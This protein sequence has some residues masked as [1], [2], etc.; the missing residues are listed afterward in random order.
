MRYINKEEPDFFKTFKKKQKPNKWSDLPPEISFQLR[1]YLV[2]TEQVAQCAYC[3]CSIKPQNSHIDHFRKRDHFPQKTF[4]YQN[5]MA[6]CNKKNSCA[7]NKDKH[8]KR[9]D[10]SNLLH[11]VEEQPIDFL[12]YT[13]T[14]DMLAIGEQLK[15]SE[16]I[17]LFHLNNASLLNQRQTIARLVK[18]YIPQLSPEEI[19][20]CIPGFETYVKWLIVQF[21]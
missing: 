15:G 9:A 17:R 5:L 12:E 2:E 3:E 19:I 20:A 7:N 10:Y 1:T 18:D 14:G 6:S 21:S 4:E 13:L 16:T 11:P 8:I